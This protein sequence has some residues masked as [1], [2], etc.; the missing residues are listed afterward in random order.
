MMSTRG[1]DVTV[2][3]SNSVFCV[4][5]LHRLAVIHD[6]IGIDDAEDAVRAALERLHAQR[7]GL[8]DLARR[9]DLV[10]QHHE[11]AFAA[12]VGGCRDAERIEQI[13]RSFVA[14]RARVPHGAHEHDGLWAS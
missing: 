3:T 10:V 12:R 2:E 5:R 14:E 9:I 4:C 13:R 8:R 11:H 1:S 7:V 6:A